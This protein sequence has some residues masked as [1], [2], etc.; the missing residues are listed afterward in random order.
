MSAPEITHAKLA[1]LHKHYGD[2]VLPTGKYWI[3]KLDGKILGVG[4]Y[5]YNGAE[6]CVFLDLTEE[7]EQYPVHLVRMGK[8]VI[9]DWEQSRNRSLS[10]MQDES[11]AT[12]KR[13][14][15]SL[16]FVKQGNTALWRKVK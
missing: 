6:C 1:D 14:L 12:S 9:K 10:V 3:G 11:K 4:G 15:E 5:F 8:R 7:A 2:R 13:W 16:G